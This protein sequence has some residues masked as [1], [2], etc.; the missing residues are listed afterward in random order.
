[1]HVFIN[2]LYQLIY[3]FKKKFDGVRYDIKFCLNIVAIKH[4]DISMD[5]D[6]KNQLIYTFFKTIHLLKSSKK[7]HICNSN[8]KPTTLKLT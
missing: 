5:L 1:M 7:I 4:I 2:L 3:F 8:S 6:L